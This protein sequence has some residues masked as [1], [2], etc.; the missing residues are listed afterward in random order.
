LP[1]YEAPNRQ[2]VQDRLIFGH[3]SA[4]GLRLDSNVLA[5]DTGC[6]WGGSLTAVRL[7]DRALFQVPCEK[8]S[9]HS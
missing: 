9:H 7:E 2:T 4:L 1:W 5:L 8:R 6:L 3:W